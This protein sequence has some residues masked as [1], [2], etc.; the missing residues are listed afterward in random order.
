MHYKEK[1]K[2]TDRKYNK[3]KFPP[4]FLSVNPLVEAKET[5]REEEE[6]NLSFF[7]GRTMFVTKAGRF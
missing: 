7:K 2:K 5:A 1:R 4:S 3:E 6:S